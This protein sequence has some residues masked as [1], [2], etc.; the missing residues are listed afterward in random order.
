MP[1]LI[2]QTNAEKIVNKGGGYPTKTFRQEIILND[3]LKTKKTILRHVISTKRN[4]GSDYVVFTCPAPDCGQRNRRSVYE[5]KGQ[6]KDGRLSFK[7]HKCYREIE[8]QRPMSLV[9]ET[10]KIPQPQEIRPG[11]LLGPNGLPI[12]R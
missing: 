12:G 7:C 8:V 1:G 9:T 2:F 3:V 6:T 10:I 5:A 4:P 11:T